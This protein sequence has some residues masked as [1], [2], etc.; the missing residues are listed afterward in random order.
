MGFRY[1]DSEVASVTAEVQK[2]YD[3]LDPSSEIG[4]AFIRVSIEDH[5]CA[6]LLS[7]RKYQMD[8]HSNLATLVY[9]GRTE[10]NPKLIIVAAWRALKEG[11]PIADIADIT[12][13][14]CDEIENLRNQNRLIF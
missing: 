14:P 2:Y 10:D 13:L 5:V 9:R 6:K 1:T 4:K 11:M 12:G 3:S 8:M 7:R